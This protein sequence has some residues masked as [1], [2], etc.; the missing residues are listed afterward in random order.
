MSTVVFEKEQMIFVFQFVDK[1]GAVKN[2]FLGVILFKKPTLLSH[3][4]VI[5]DFFVNIGIA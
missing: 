5:D 2:I 3:N 1:N 4:F